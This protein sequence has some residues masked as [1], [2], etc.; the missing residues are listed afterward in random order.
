MRGRMAAIAVASTTLMLSLI[1]PPLSLLAAAAVAL[2][3]LR[4]GFREGLNTLLASA[5]AAGLLGAIVLGNFVLPAGYGLMLWLPAWAFALLLRQSRDMGL[6]FEAMAILGVVGTLLFFLIQPDPAAFW[7]QRLALIFKPL[8]QQAGGT[9]QAAL[10]Q[11]LAMIA[12]YLTGIMAAG[13]VSS[14]ALSLLL[15]RWWQS[16]LFNP[17]GFRQEFLTMQLHRSLAYFSIG[18][19][20]VAVV[21]EGRFALATINM[22]VVVFTLYSIFGTAILHAIFSARGKRA[23]LIGMYVLMLFIPHVFLPIAMVG[24]GDAWVDWRGRFALANQ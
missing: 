15:A 13:M 10:E 23:L 17:G 18:L 2:V 3:T 5:L 1:L 20:A 19:V 12:R 4:L 9:D 6:T 21:T 16:L 14:L 11:Q 8:W 7:Q 24:L 22:G